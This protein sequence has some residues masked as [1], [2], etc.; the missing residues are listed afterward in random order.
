MAS[1]PSRRRRQASDRREHGVGGDD[2]VTLRE[3]QADARVEQLLLRIENVERRS[4]AA[5]ASSRTP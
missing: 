3:D 2:A 4:F 1:T 5:L